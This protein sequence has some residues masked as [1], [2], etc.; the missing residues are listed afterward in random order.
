MVD[1]TEDRFRVARL[2]LDLRQAGITDGPALSGMELV[3]REAFV[4]PESVDLA[5]EDCVLPIP[6][7][8]LMPRPRVVAGIVSALD[9]SSLVSPRVLVIGAGSGYT[10]AVLAAAGATVWG[11][12]RF[13]GLVSYARGRL[14]AA[15]TTGVLLKCA[16]GLEGWPEAAPFDRIVL[17]GA[18]ELVPD[19]LFRQLS[20]QGQILA[21][22][23]SDDGQFVRL[24]RDEDRV[25]RVISASRFL[26]LSPGVARVL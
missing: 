9:L 1:D 26:P 4:E 25:G 20:S 15:G 10:C 6:C 22:I 8:Q 17:M 14:Q 5:Y 7:G 13:H 16:D 18:V 11:V 24:L 12:E 19:A 2:V 21:P 3:P 23:E